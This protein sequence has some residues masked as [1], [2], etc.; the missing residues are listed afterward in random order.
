MSAM[1]L[2]ECEKVFDAALSS[3]TESEF[4]LVIEPLFKEYEILS[5]EFGRG[6]IFWRA[7]IIESAVYSNLSELDYPPPNLAKQG[8]LNDH[9]SP[10]FYISARKETA[11]AEVGAKEGQLVQLAGFR[12][13]NEFPLRLAVIGEYSNVQKNGY[14]HFAG[15][16]PEMAITK[17]LNSMPRQEAFK[18][19]YID[20]FFANVLADPNAS[21]NGYMFSR[22]LSQAIYSRNSSVAIVFP[23]VKDRGGFNVAVKA[24]ES[25]NSFHNVSCIV[26]ELKKQRRFGI[27]EF[28]IVKSAER[29]DENWNF[30]WKEGNS[31]E[32]IGIYNMSK[33]EYDAAMKDPHDRNNLLNMLSMHSKGT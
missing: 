2:D 25:D 8:R 28:D 27:I 32:T 22:A 19:I 14:M 1:T 29:L 33:E 26:V 11:L 4:C 21:E 12:I 23:S 17:I 30:I 16:D 9:G 5:L 31:S 24:K 3:T 7:R 13:V 20:K 10:C 18:K 15:K 6:S